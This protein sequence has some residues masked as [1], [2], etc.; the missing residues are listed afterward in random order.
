MTRE[1]MDGYPAA[2]GRERIGRFLRHAFPLRLSS[3]P[4]LLMD[5]EAKERVE[6]S[7]RR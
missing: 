4:E 7:S 6:A 3:F 1:L 5:L 2:D